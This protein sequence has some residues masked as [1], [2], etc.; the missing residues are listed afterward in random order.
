[1]VTVMLAT[2]FVMLVIF[3]IY[4]IGHQHPKSVTNILNRSQTSHTCHQHIWYPKSVTNI[5][6]TV[7]MT[8]YAPTSP[9]ITSIFRS[10]ANIF[11]LVRLPNQ[12][13][14]HAQFFI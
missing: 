10:K 9:S 8:T 3:S 2:F 6:V 12:L 4:Q 1:M 5:D 7:K 11:W 14:N 13:P